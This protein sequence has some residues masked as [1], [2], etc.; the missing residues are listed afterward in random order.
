MATDDSLKPSKLT[1]SLPLIRRMN[2]HAEIVVGAIDT[3][4]YAHPPLL[5][6]TF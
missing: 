3:F 5:I 6:I 1:K 4:K 2:R